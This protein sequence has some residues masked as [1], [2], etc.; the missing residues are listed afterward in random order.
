MAVYELDDELSPTDT[1]EDSIDVRV[2]QIR[3]S[4]TTNRKNKRKS[5]EP[6]RFNVQESSEFKRRRLNST[7]SEERSQN[8]SGSRS[9]SPSPSSPSLDTKKSPEPISPQYLAP[10]KR[11]K[12]D[13]L[14]EIQRLKDEE[15]AE[16]SDL[17]SV[18]SLNPFRPWSQTAESSPP[19]TPVL[20]PEM[21]CIP[22][23]LQ[24]LHG[25]VPL[26]FLPGLLQPSILIPSLPVQDEPLSLVKEKKPEIL[27]KSDKVKKAPRTDK[28]IESSPPKKK[29]IKTEPV[30]IKIEPCLKEEISSPDDK[31]KQR[32]YK[33]LTRERRIEANARERQRVH[34]ITAAFDTL[35]AAIPSEDENINISTLSVITIAAA[36]IMALSRMAGYDYTEDRSAPSL[37]SVLEHC[38]ETIHTESRIKKRV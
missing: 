32:N 16:K 36:S 15:S 3:S 27:P 38:R 17:G 5:N 18:N 23:L 4:S 33:N 25:D 7:G 35:Q 22:F 24:G 2:K 10:K 8:L 37:E 31:S 12:L 14:R 26:A 29:S 1:S 30:T 11:F 9:P 28:N 19:P 13:A 20:R 21:P 6:R 34:T